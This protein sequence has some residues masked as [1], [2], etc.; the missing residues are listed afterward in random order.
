MKKLATLVK[1]E[2]WENKGALFWT[3]IAIGLISVGLMLMGIVTQMVI[4]NESYT[5]REAMRLV[6]G[7]SEETR[8]HYLTMMM[9]GGSVFF[10]A[11][12]AFVNLFYLLGAL[13]DDRKDKSILFW[14][15]LPA[16][17]LL[18]VVSKL[19]VALLLV[20]LIFWAVFVL[21]QVVQGLIGS[22]MVL[23]VGENPWSLFIGPAEPLRAWGLVLST[24]LA[25]SVWF[26]PFV[27]WLLL[28]S[29]WSPRMPLLFAFVPPVIFAV[30]QTWIR[31]LRTFTFGESN[32][33]GLIGKWFADSP[34]LISFQ[35]DDHKPEAALGIPLTGNF[36][37]TISLANILDR[38]FSIPALTGA[39]LALV[40]LAGAWLLRRRSADI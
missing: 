15:S 37:H 12:M 19:I 21:T 1:R 27:G 32:L 2:F 40:M 28:V 10:T 26:L 5:F 30:L 31:F 8:S 24:Y 4:D 13:Y 22:L 3:P 39:L 16:S 7:E 33:F 23:S 29:A 25:S 14:K 35:V 36:E 20:P 17:D 38:V 6:A 11:V 34:L 9:M 18:T